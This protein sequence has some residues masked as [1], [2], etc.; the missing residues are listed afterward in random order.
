[1]K[2]DRRKF[3]DETTGQLDAAFD[4]MDELLE[5]IDLYVEADTAASCNGFGCFCDPHSEVKR[6]FEGSQVGKFV[7]YTSNDENE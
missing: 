7:E 3:M 2:I 1:M 5:F 4:A 6:Y